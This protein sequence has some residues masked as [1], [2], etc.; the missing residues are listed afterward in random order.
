MKLAVARIGKPHGVKGEVTVESLT[1]APDERFVVGAIL[2]SDST[3]F[4]SLEIIRVRIHQGTWMLTFA[5]VSDRTTIERLRNSRLYADV[6]IE[7]EIDEEDGDSYHIEQ[8]RGMTVQ[9]RAGVHIGDVVGVQH[10][11]GQ[12]L[13]EV[14]TPRGVRLIPLVHQ[15]ILDVDL[16]NSRILVDLPEGL[17]E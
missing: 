8:L 6:D 10:L 17:V 7:E 4:A 2:E 9:D 3:I 11:P 16:E 5:E 12:D 1:D 13:L 15:F 14:G